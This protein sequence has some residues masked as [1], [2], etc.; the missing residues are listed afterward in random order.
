MAKKRI[1]VI[2]DEPDFVRLLQARLQIA[3]YEVLTAEDG[4]KGIQA[5]RRDEPDIIILDIMMPG[6]DGHMVC[7]MLKKST[8]TWSIPVIYMTARDSQ[9]DEIL[10]LEK[11]AK[12]Y[13]TKPYNPEM[14]LEMIKSA[15]MEGEEQEKRQGRVMIIDQDL[16]QVGELEARLKHSGYEVVYA[17][18][19]GQGVSLAI[20]SPP[21][22]ILLD[23]ATSHADGHAAVKALG[24][25]KSLV[26]TSLF[27]LAPQSV[28]D[29]VGSG[30]AQIENFIRKPVNYAQ[31]L[32]TLQR[33]LRQKK[34]RA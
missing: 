26:T 16:S 30:T 17:S 20:E 3:G 6:L 13:L 34:D 32:D 11:G 14:L 25:E 28:L 18:T 19:A 33:V 9:A 8:L 5:A 7:D 12:Y 1:L 10:A 31:L 29:R 15:L 24:R 2:D 22:V 27:I 23:F 4:I 21:D